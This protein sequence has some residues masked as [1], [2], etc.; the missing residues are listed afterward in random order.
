MLKLVVDRRHRP[1]VSERVAYGHGVIA[2]QCV[3]QY[4]SNAS[5]AFKLPE[6]TRRAFGPLTAALVRVFLGLDRKHHCDST[7]AGHA[8]REKEQ[9]RGMMSVRM[10]FMACP[11]SC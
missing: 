5:V 8:R 4:A 10:A 6:P 3:P 7:V 2:G 9:G 11:Q 1:G